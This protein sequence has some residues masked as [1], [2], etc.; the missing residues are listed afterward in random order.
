[1]M[2]RVYGGIAESC[3]LVSLLLDCLYSMLVLRLQRTGR[4]RVPTYRIVLA[5]KSSAAKGRFQEILGHYLLNRDPP[6]FQVN[7]ERVRYWVKHGA[8]PSD[9]LARTFRKNGV[10]GMEA[11]ICRYARRKPKNAS[12][13]SAAVAQPTVGDS[14][15]GNG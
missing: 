3:G 2:K 13:E 4:S 7:E 12:E 6:V 5:E 10:A 14:A 11:F 9:T 8:I 1:M 15:T